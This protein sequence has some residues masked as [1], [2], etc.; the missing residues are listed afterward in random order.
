MLEIENLLFGSGPRFRKHRRFVNL[1]FNQRATVRLH[2]LQMK[3]AFTLVVG[4]MQEPKLFM[5]HFRRQVT[6]DTIQ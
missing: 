4:F 5:E 6:L 2:P 3:E 1:T